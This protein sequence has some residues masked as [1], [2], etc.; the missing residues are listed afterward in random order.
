MMSRKEA[1]ELI[2]KMAH[3]LAAAM[4]HGGANVQV[5]V[6]DRGFAK[7]KDWFYMTVGSVGVMALLFA[8]SQLIFL[9]ESV[10]DLNGQ[11]RTVISQRESDLAQ[12]EVDRVNERR[13]LD[14]INA[15]IALIESRK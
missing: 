4:G 7:L 15:R 5:G 2:A 12:R 9:R 3:D 1:E 13:E 8:S 10:V 11:L 6:Q 14:S